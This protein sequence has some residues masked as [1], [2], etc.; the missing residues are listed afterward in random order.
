MLDQTTAFPTIEDAFWA[1]SQNVEDT[2]LEYYG[3]DHATH[4]KAR[5]L[6]D[7][8]VKSVFTPEA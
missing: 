5:N 6:Y 2:V 3:P 8:L 4:I 1:Y 7:S